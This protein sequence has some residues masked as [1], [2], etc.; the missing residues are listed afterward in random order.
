MAVC[1]SQLCWF[2]STLQFN[3]QR[4]LFSSVMGEV[5]PP[6]NKKLKQATLT[7]HFQKSSSNLLLSTSP[8]TIPVTI[9]QPSSTAMPSP[10]HQS[11]NIDFTNGVHNTSDLVNIN[12]Y[13]PVWN[14]KQWEK[15][16]AKYP[17]FLCELGKLEC[18][19]CADVKSII[20]PARGV[21]LSAQWIGIQIGSKTAK[22]LKDK[23]YQ[24]A[25]SDAHKAAEKILSY[26]AHEQVTLL[27][28]LNGIK[29]GNVHRTDHSCANI[30]KSIAFSM[31]KLLCK[32]ITNDIRFVSLMLDEATL[33]TSSVII[34]YL[35]ASLCIK[36][37]VMILESKI[38]FSV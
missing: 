1:H 23:I 13:P 21:H 10:S 9:L 15:W 32:R 5:A 8:L 36:T 28:E 4:L 2:V 22:K 24:H 14:K 17:F 31:K 25:S 3:N 27:Q 35:Q 29:I 37:T 16:F 38:Y 20:K 11:P 7:A 33:F 19:T 26:K 18:L 30:L 34:I 12:K 6:P